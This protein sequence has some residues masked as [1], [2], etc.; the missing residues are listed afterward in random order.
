MQ[1]YQRIKLV[2]L[3]MLG[4]SSFVMLNCLL[5]ILLV[6]KIFPECTE[7]ILYLVQ[8][9]LKRTPDWEVL[10]ISALALLAISLKAVL[11]ISACWLWS[12]QTS[13]SVTKWP[14]E[15]LLTGTVPHHTLPSGWQSAGC[16]LNHLQRLIN[17]A[18]AFEVLLLMRASVGFLVFDIVN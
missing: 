6:F 12:R 18:K 2:K 8:S 9:L 1:A 13:T 5:D 10:L 17:R 16:L 3:S 4:P 15:R 11:V 7:Y 14:L